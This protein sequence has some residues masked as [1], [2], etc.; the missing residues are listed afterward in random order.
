MPLNNA[1]LEFISSSIDYLLE[2][3]TDKEELTT[4]I[5]Q[6]TAWL[7]TPPN[8]PDNNNI[9]YALTRYLQSPE[10]T[11]QHLEDYG[12]EATAAEVQQ[13]ILHLLTQAL[14]ITANKMGT[15][16]DQLGWNSANIQAALADTKKSA[17]FKS[18]PTHYE[19]PLLWENVHEDG[20]TFT[21]S[22]AL[23]ENGITVMLNVDIHLPD[24]TDIIRHN[25]CYAEAPEERYDEFYFMKSLVR[26]AKKRAT[27]IAAIEGYR[28]LNAK[29][30]LPD[31]YPLEE[32]NVKNHFHLLAE[33]E[34]LELIFNQV[35]SLSVLAALSD[36]IIKKLQHPV[37]KKLLLNNCCTLDLISQLPFSTLNIL[38]SYSTLLT[39]S[40]INL[41]KLRS[42]S[43]DQ[44]KILQHTAIINL[45]HQRKLS[46]KAAIKLPVRVLRLLSS[47]LY[48]DYFLKKD[49]KWKRFSKL[50]PSRMTILLS[51]AIANC[52]KQNIIKL[53]DVLYS[54]KKR[55]EKLQL[56]KIQHLLE[57]NIVTL[58]NLD[59][60]STEK[61]DLIESH[62]LLCEWL[63]Q[64]IIT[65]NDLLLR[66]LTPLY[67]TAYSSRLAAL[68]NGSPYVLY[69]NQTDSVETILAELPAVDHH[70]ESAAGT[71]QSKITDHLLKMIKS[72]IE[73][74]A[75]N[76]STV[77]EKALYI[78][79]CRAIDTINH[80]DTNSCE[81]LADV[82]DYA[83]KLNAKRTFSHKLFF[84]AQ[85][86]SGEF[87]TLC[88]TLNQLSLLARTGDNT[89]KLTSSHFR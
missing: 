49:I 4:G 12:K 43:N 44:Q 65:I 1:Q 62:P 16:L 15:S 51:P 60:L 88:E 71:L 2:F 50:S 27:A 37:A 55:R 6:F 22:L 66:S 78:E 74:S 76:A 63:K 84:S 13:Y 52:I 58:K 26:H 59:Q 28:Y 86:V 89:V 9:F 34:I 36:D 72:R 21:F 39:S 54:K 29:N 53:D 18:V 33:T 81:M 45:I 14:E 41:K 79:L 75:A 69:G 67:I 40:E 57:S 48:A 20:Q 77:K 85:C 47:P 7:S 25:E 56:H 80:H 23:N 87:G 38:K 8:Q 32:E 19:I 83:N 64:G 17:A 73:T 3:P 30:L 24:G 31:N 82:I 70:T 10:S 42:L 11:L 61:C 5:K 35:L 46:I 68:F